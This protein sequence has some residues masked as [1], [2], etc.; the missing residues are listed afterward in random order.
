LQSFIMSQVNSEVHVVPF[1]SFKRYRTRAGQFK[2]N[3][4]VVT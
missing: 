4:S 3:D 2:K 1:W